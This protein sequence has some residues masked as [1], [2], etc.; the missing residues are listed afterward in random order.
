MMVPDLSLA[1]RFLDQAGIPG[2]L[3]LCGVTG[4]HHYGFPSPDSDIDL[5]AIH[6]APTRSLLG[7]DAPPETWDVIEEFERVEC[8]LTSHEARKA[9]GLL[10]GGN[11]NLLERILSPIQV[12]LSEELDELQ[13]LARASISRGFFGHYRGYFGGMQR[14]HAL[15][16]RVKS[17]LYTHRVALT[18]VH[19]LRT[20]EL[21]ADVRVNG[22]R[23]GFDDVLELVELKASGAEKATLDP[24][25]DARFR[26]NWPRLEELLQQAHDD[27]SLPDE[28]P[29][30]EELVDW[31]VRARLQEL[32]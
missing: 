20:G 1:R 32:R 24:E 7:L 12:V 9:I 10:A 14:E 13:E 27:S 31:L 29:N 28:P 23:Y 17:M 16:P 5:K 22:S 3:L 8:D 25:L 6:L 21:E 4:A 18:G 19:L 30:R 11:G 26:A 15:R 2:R